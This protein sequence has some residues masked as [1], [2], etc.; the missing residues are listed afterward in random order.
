MEINIALDFNVQM[1]IVIAT[2][3]CH[4][5]KR[6]TPRCARHDGTKVP[7]SQPLR[8]PCCHTVRTDKR[9][10]GN[11]P[12]SEATVLNTI[13]FKSARIARGNTQKVKGTP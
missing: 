6:C 9:N 11:V 3:E 4:A 12:L 7:V 5:L 2:V 1:S 13:I 8:S 10:I